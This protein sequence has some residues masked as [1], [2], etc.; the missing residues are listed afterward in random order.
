MYPGLFGVRRRFETGGS[1]ADGAASNGREFAADPCPGGGV[2]TVSPVSP[3]AV[4]AGTCAAVYCSTWDRRVE[5]CRC[6]GLCG[7]GANCV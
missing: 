7:A 2:M 1:C 5:L 6:C 4:D 3:E